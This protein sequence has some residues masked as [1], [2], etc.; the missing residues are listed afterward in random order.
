M[1]KKKKKKKPSK[2]EILILIVVCVLMVSG[3]FYGYFSEDNSEKSSVSGIFNAYQEKKRRSNK[4]TKTHY[5]VFLDGTKY[6]IPRIYISALNKKSFLNEVKPGD[7][8]TLE[9]DGGKS[10]YQITKAQTNYI[11]P[12]KLKEDIESNN[13]V[14][15]ILGCF[16][17]GCIFYLIYVYTRL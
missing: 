7:S 16:F 3:I 2:K 9:L 13:F 4:S 14:G 8:L 5:F 17:L 15:L 10:I 12:I 11:D 1:G 6:N